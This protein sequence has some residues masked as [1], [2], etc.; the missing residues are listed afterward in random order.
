MSLAEKRM[1]VDVDVV[2]ESQGPIVDQIRHN[3]QLQ[4]L[5]MIQF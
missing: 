3:L 4:P 2:Q 1:E 5:F